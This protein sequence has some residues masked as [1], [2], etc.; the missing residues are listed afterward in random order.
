MVIYHINAHENTYEKPPKLQLFTNKPTYTERYRK[1]RENG[2]D[3]V[4]E[5]ADITSIRSDF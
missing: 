1:D 3:I 5:N 4:N 2:S